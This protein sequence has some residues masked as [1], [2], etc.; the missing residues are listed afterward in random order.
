MYA[1]ILSNVKNRMSWLAF[2][3]QVRRKSGTI[4][5]RPQGTRTGYFRPLVWAIKLEFRSRY[6]ENFKIT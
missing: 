3:P 1:I 6:Q 4:R 5:T 2:L